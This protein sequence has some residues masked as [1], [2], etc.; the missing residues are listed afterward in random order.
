MAKKILAI[1]L[2][3][4]V[5]SGAWMVL[6][7]VT[8]ERTSSARRTMEGQVAE[9]WGASHKQSAPEVFYMDES[10]LVPQQSSP[11]AKE[12]AK[13]EP[14]RID[15]VPQAS[16]IKVDLHLDQ[17]KKGLL[18]FSTYTVGFDGLYTIANTTG[19]ARDI[20]VVFNLPTPEAVYD[21]LRFTID[22]KDTDVGAAANGRLSA[23]IFLGAGQEKQV[24]VQYRSRGMDNWVYMFGRG[25]TQV[26][27]F[28]LEMTTDFDQIDFPARTIS[29]TAKEKTD[30]G[31]RLT[32][33]HRN[34]VSGFTL[35]ME[36]P[37]RLNPGPLASQISFFAPISLLFFFFVV[38]ILGI[39]RNIKL[40]P[41]HYMF[42][43]AAFFSFHLLFAY[44]VDHIDVNLAFIISSLTS[45]GLVVS[46]L[47][48]VVSKA[49][50][51]REAAL[52]QL[53][54][55]VLFSYTHFFTGFTGLSVTIV[56]I[57][58]LA[59]AMHLTARI[60]W[61]EKFRAL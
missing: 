54:Y 32:W 29:P 50:A 39:I 58:T 52:A 43:A 40:H 2:I 3:Y 12:P 8:M 34:L 9:L 14:Q 49:F 6:G 44:L 36:M 22:G 60:D 35:G 51:Y 11:T 61:D 41:M 59:A 21:D 48:V 38:F 30:S 13:V 28:H 31:W 53:L 26:K 55:L 25:A 19:Q 57:M 47:R 18:W 5:T 16:D 27:N 45:V 4:M 23:A 56:A 46:Y 33:D 20:S 7:G 15:L 1:M 37:K 42:L 17:R 10:V 24:R